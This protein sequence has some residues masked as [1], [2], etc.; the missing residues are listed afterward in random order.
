MSI[1]GR[2]PWDSALVTA[3]GA[4]PAR[5]SAAAAATAI[6]MVRYME[7]SFAVLREAFMIII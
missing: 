6:N 5:K 7:T 1:S 2:R 3:L 4:Q